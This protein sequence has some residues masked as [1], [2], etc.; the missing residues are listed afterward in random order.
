MI[1]VSTIKEL[2]RRW[3]PDLLGGFT[4]ENRTSR[5]R[6]HSRI[7]RGTGVLPGALLQAAVAIADRLWERSLWELLPI[8]MNHCLHSCR[9]IAQSMCSTTNG[10]ALAR[11][12][13]Q[14]RDDARVVRRVAERDRQIALP[15]RDSR[16]GA[17]RCLRC[18]RGTL[19]ATSRTA[20]AAACGRGV[21]RRQSPLRRSAAQ[22]DSTGRRAGNR[23]NRRSDSRSTRAARAESRPCVRSSGTKCSGARR[24][25]AVP[26]IA[27]VGHT[28]EHALQRPQ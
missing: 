26:T 24:V 20:R 17:T 15:L 16:S 5:A 22:S 7:D 21:P 3:S 25:R 1:D 27:P 23:R 4:K 14:C 12:A 13:L 11:A 9:S 2:A 18:A 19:P 8:A 28:D 10:A 6:G